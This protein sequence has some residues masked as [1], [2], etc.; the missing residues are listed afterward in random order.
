ML[1]LLLICYSSWRKM[2]C[3]FADSVTALPAAT[4]SPLRRLDTTAPGAAARPHYHYRHFAVVAQ[5]VV[6]ADGSP[7]GRAEHA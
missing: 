4:S 2:S 1:L 5:P 7:P 3:W 6:A